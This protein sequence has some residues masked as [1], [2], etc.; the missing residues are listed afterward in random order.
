[1]VMD[2]IEH[3][4]KYQ[5]LYMRNCFKTWISNTKMNNMKTRRRQV[6]IEQNEQEQI[7]AYSQA[8]LENKRKDAKT[9]MVRLQNRQQFKKGRTDYLIGVMTRRNFEQDFYSKKR[10][11]LCTW[12]HC[13][14]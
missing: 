7:I 8:Q 10:L 1:M 3:W 4:R 13:V 14:K 9:Q 12:R 5:F 6:L 2:V 11:I